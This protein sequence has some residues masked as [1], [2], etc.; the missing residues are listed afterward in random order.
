MLRTEIDRNPSGADCAIFTKQ[1]AGQNSVKHGPQARTERT[2]CGIS[3]FSDFQ[4]KFS[5]LQ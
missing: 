3:F 5:F 4:E 1:K 2:A